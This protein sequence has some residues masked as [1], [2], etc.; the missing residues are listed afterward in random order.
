[1]IVI[2]L[3][4]S[5]FTLGSRLIYQVNGFHAIE[6]NGATFDYYFGLFSFSYV[7]TDSGDDPSNYVYPTEWQTVSYQD[8]CSTIWFSTGLNKGQLIDMSFFCSG[9][10]PWQIVTPFMIVAVIL[11]ILALGLLIA[12]GITFGTF[13][14]W[15]KKIP[16]ADRFC[17]SRFFKYS[18]LCCVL[19]HFTFQSSAMALT[20]AFV[21]L[22]M[23]A[24]PSHLSF[25]LG[26]IVSTGSLLNDV[27]FMVM[28]LC[29]YDSM[30]VWKLE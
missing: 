22:N 24:L 13:H 1:M 28:F 4:T 10:S 29:L 17:L 5:S 21:F 19:L 11:G 7:M 6:F 25:G 30:F 12:N 27:F 16:I 8:A 23:V 2:L 18:I 9:K 3:T 20:A 26:A 15:S 14:L